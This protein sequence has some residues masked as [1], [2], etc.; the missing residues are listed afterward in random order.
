MSTILSC[1]ECTAE[2]QHPYKVVIDEAT[3]I[4]QVTI[5][6][7]RVHLLNRHIQLP[8]VHVDVTAGGGTFGLHPPD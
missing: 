5:R 2:G 4:D 7:M 1:R 8:A 3:P 6:T